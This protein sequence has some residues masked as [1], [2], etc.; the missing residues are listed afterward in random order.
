MRKTLLVSTAALV[1]GIAMGAVPTL[2]QTSGCMPTNC[3]GANQPSTSGQTSE[4]IQR[5][6][7][8]QK[9]NAGQSGTTVQPANQAPQKRRSGQAR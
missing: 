3:P 7:S 8:G 2:A 1:T 9:S 5:S 6:S 4:K